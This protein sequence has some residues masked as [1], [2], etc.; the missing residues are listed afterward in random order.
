[1]ELLSIAA[2][3]LGTQIVQR[4]QDQPAVFEQRGKARVGAGKFRAG[5]RVA[6]DGEHAV[7]QGL[8]RLDDG[9][10]TITPHTRV[11]HLGVRR[12]FGCGRIHDRSPRTVQLKPGVRAS[13]SPPG[14]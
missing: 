8:E 1:M 14:E 7:G 3:L 5:D 9:D 6:G 4:R 13:P 12:F 2:I 11:G 10:G